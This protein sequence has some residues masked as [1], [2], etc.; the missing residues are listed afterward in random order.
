MSD[1]IL[2]G[3]RYELSRT[4]LHDLDLTFAAGRMTALSGPSGSGKTTLLS[5]AGGLLRPTTG[6]A[7]YAGAPDSTTA[8][9]TS[10]AVRNSITT[11]P[12]I[13]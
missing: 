9:R 4:L 8:S 3:V 10:T 12:V 5:I 2:S 6:E 7:T 11:T 13:R 1:L